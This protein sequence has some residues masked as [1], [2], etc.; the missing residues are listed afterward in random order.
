MRT[1]WRSLGSGGVASPISPKGIPLGYRSPLAGNWSVVASARRSCPRSL[2][3]GFQATRRVPWCAWGA[4]H[5][6]ANAIPAVPPMPVLGPRGCPSY[7]RCQNGVVCTVSAAPRQSPKQT[8]AFCR[9]QSA[10]LPQFS[11]YRLRLSCA[12]PTLGALPKFAPGLADKSPLGR[13]SH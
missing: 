6:P 7:S 10:C 2:G 11:C 9:N 3:G 1:R 12:L 5:S 13:L 8:A 4:G